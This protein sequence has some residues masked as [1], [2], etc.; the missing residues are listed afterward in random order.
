MKNDEKEKEKNESIIEKRK[1]E[2]I[3]RAM[4]NNTQYNKKTGFESIEL[5]HNALPEIDFK[6]VE[7]KLKFLGKEINAPIM[8]EA[9]TGGFDG[10]K[11]I[12]KKLAEA[13][14]KYNIPFG[15]GSQRAMLEN[16]KDVSYKVRDVAP[17][18]VIIGNIGAIQLKKYET[19]DIE[20]LVSKIELDGFAIHLNPLQEIIQSEGDR[21]FSGLLKGIEKICSNLSV[22]I[23]VKETGAGINKEVAKKL[24]GVGV[25]YID[26]AGAGGTSWSKIEYFRGNGIEGFGEWGIP[27]VKS[28]EEC[29]GILPLIASGGIR[30]GIDIAKSLALGAEL[31]G[32]ALPFLIAC[33]NNKTN[34][35]NE[36]IELWINQLKIAMFLT[37]SKN[38]KEIKSVRL[39]RQ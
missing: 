11:K 22:P 37:G 13:A 15:L 30:N 36:L 23:I 6:D 9:M 8:I 2:H 34:K 5:I 31:G 21:N 39:E 33:K 32:A 1:R 12:N 3:E 25:K 16:K 19:K 29:K 35:L 38:I 26:V 18:A 4:E 28:I 7:T 27:T 10:A 17:T 14:E 20:S 24:K